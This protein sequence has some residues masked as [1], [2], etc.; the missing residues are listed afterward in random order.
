MI[1]LQAE[2]PNDSPDPRLMK[3]THRN[4]LL[5]LTP[6]LTIPVVALATAAN[7]V[8][9]EH[10][11]RCHGADGTANTK[12]GKKLK[13]RDYSSETVQ[14]RMTDEDIYQAIAEGVFDDRGKERMPAYKS[15]LS[16]KEITDLVATVRAFKK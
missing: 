11:A 2:P 10:C 12:I 15:K 4:I 7:E 16:E 13:L 8:W 3:K 9:S 5:L 6:L 14:A 1:K